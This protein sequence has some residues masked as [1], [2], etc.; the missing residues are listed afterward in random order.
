MDLPYRIIP[1]VDDEAGRARNDAIRS[2]VGHCRVSGEFRGHGI[3]R[4]FRRAWARTRLR[5]AFAPQQ[6]TAGASEAEL[7]FNAERLHPI[8]AE[9]G[10][11]L[12]AR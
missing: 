8:D 6:L 12:G 11:R 9:C 7:V 1:Q 10:R 5:H 4:F 2:G 3:R